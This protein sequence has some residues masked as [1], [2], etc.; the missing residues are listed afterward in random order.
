MYFR[1]VTALNSINRLFLIGVMLLPA[2]WRAPIARAQVDGPVYIVQ[3]GDSY[4]AIAASFK[5]AIPDLLAA[6]GFSANHVINPGDRLV[7]PGYEGIHGILSTRIVELGESLATLSLRTGVP[8]DTLL[9]LNRLVNPERLF[10]G[11]ELIILEPDADAAGI[12]RWETG[13]MLSLSTGTPLLALAAAEGKNPWELTGVNNLSSQ[14]D[15]FSGQSLLT[16]GG[17]QPLRA[18]PAPL[19]DIQFRSL[20]LVQGMTSEIFITLSGDSRVAGTLGDWPLNFR[21]LGERLVTLQGIHAMAAPGTYPFRLTVTLADGRSQ[22]FEQDMLLI[23]GQ[24]PQDPDLKVPPET[25]DPQTIDAESEQVRSIVAPFTETR[26]WEGLFLAPAFKGITS[27]YGSRRS[28]NNGAYYSFHSGVD[29]A[30]RE[31]DPILAP[32]AGRVIFTG[33]LTIC[34]NATIIDHGWGIYSRYCHQH[35][36]EVQPGERVEPGQEIG[37]IG[38]TGRAD[39]P[40]LHWEIWAGGVQVNPLTWLQE[41]FP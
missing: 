27:M 3:E 29:Y 19:E 8:V 40:H 14:A 37:L 36:I 38:R 13:R 21:E 41:I 24:Y 26:F 25:L 5:V 31:K 33:P 34:G 30:G 16:V 32:A 12:R 20:P 15:Q 39:G 11:Q 18:W 17:D 1:L 23:S 10:A 7:I 9:R 2:L 22:I 28:Y 6:N 35:T 4:W